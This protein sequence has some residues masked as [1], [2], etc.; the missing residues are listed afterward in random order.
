MRNAIGQAVEAYALAWE[1]QRLEG[2]NLSELIGKIE[3]RR[4]QPGYDFLS[5]SSPEQ[6]RFIEVKAVGKLRG[7]EGYH[8]FL[9][10]NERSISRFPKNEETYF[11]YLVFFNRP[12]EPCEL[13]PVPA[14]LLYKSCEVSPATY[15]VRFDFDNKM[16]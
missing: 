16:Q 10:D 7:G 1:T 14:S 6:P 3:D 9:S 8:F 4:D 12:G 15:M 5:H 2:A 13:R 11:F